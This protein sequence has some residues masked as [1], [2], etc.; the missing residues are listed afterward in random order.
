MSGAPEGLDRRVADRFEQVATTSARYSA[1]G[2]TAAVTVVGLWLAWSIPAPLYY[3]YE[4]LLAV[5]I[6]IGWLNFGVSKRFGAGHWLVYASAFADMG[7]LT[8]AILSDNPFEEAPLPA[9]LHYRFDGFV[10]FFLLFAGVLHSYSP[11]LVLWSGVSMALWW[12]GALA[13]SV[14]APGVVTEFS[15]T[16]AEEMSRLRL[17][18]RTQESDF[19]EVLGRLQEA[20]VAVLVAVIAS[21]AVAQSRRLVFENVRAERARENLARYFS[22]E[23]AAELASDEHDLGAARRQDAAVLFADIVGFTRLSESL[24]PEGTIAL[25]R[26]WHGRLGDI[27]FRHGGTLDKYIGDG[28]MATFGAPRVRPDDASRALAAGLEMAA[29]ARRPRPGAGPEAGPDA[30]R[31]PEG[32]P[33]VRIGVGIHFGPVVVGDVGNERRLEF[34]VLGDTVNVASRLEGL[35]R[36]L[37]AD[38]VASG[39]LVARV[40]EEG[41][42][43]GRLVSV[44]ER[45]L[46]GRSEPVEAFVPEGP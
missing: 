44:G 1:W 8:F 29:E 6:A 34:A 20:L 7:L 22:P 23:V 9:A 3:Y 10:F 30:S 39:D 17:V 32:P 40:R 15:L 28:L 16:G 36:E 5:F 27:V 38:L 46:R 33:P 43:A 14:Q 25:L 12:T 24:G 35:T 18:E 2:R 19:I 11:R 21:F 37:G 45:S 4:A 41:G 31:R 42:P 26:E 13:L